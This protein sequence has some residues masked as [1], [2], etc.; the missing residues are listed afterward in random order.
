MI[1]KKETLP[2]VIQSLEPEGQKSDELQNCNW[3][4]VPYGAVKLGS[5]SVKMY[6]IRNKFSGEY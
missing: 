4:R 1:C 2:D 5:L 6:S 3:V